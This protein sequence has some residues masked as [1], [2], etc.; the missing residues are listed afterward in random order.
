MRRASPGRIVLSMACLLLA[1]CGQAKS[2]AF[3]GPVLATLTGQISAPS[4]VQIDGPVEMALIW[5]KADTQDPAWMDAQGVDYAAHFPIDYTVGIHAPPPADALRGSTEAMGLLVAYQDVNGNGVLDR[6]P[7]GGHAVDRIVGTSV[8]PNAFMEDGIDEYFVMFDESAANDFGSHGP[9]GFWIARLAGSF[10]NPYLGAPDSIPITATDSRWANM[11]VCEGLEGGWGRIDQCLCRD[12][13]D[14]FIQARLHA[15]DAAGTAEALIGTCDGP[16]KGAATVTL[17]GQPLS[18][19]PDAGAYVLNEAVRSTIRIGSNTFEASLSGHVSAKVSGT[20]HAV[21][22]TSPASGATVRVGDSV[23]TTWTS[24]GKPYEYEYYLR[25]AAGTNWNEVETKSTSASIGF[26][27]PGRW[28]IGVDT[29]ENGVFTSAGSSLTTSA[30][31][32]VSV[33]VAP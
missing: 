7:V 2:S 15:A 3:E 11:V 10:A 18:W 28:S 20:L 1:G 29:V 25:D 33:T 30:T 12:P 5:E 22:L 16:A 4:N 32:T 23:T 24:T 9:T 17:N 8:G 14:L 6:I 21:T 26:F 31:G 13:G 27:E 19:A